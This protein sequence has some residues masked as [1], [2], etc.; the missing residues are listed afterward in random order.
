MIRGMF[1][2]FGMDETRRDDYDV[3]A[4]LEH[5]EED[6]L[7]SFLEFYHDV[8]PEMKSV[9]KVVQFKVGLDGDKWCSYLVH[10]ISTSD[11][12]YLYK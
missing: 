9:G 1:T 10:H 8:L 5:S 7:D 11:C 2:T 3:D 6:I 12:L 4:W